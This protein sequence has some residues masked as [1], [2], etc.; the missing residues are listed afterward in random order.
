MALHGP[1]TVA[2][3]GKAGNLGNSIRVRALRALGFSGRARH[4]TPDQTYTVLTALRTLRRQSGSGSI[5][6]S[7]RW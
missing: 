4:L 5:L 7:C 1:K 3:V 2:W 6:S